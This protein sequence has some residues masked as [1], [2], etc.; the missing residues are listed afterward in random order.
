MSCVAES[1]FD[2]V[3]ELLD[4]I[5]EALKYTDGMNE[6]V[7][8]MRL[9][10]EWHFEAWLD[11]YKLKP[12]IHVTTCAAFKAE[13]IH[14]DPVNLNLNVKF[15]NLNFK[16]KLNLKL[17]IFLN[18][19]QEHR[20]AVYVKEA[21]HHTQWQSEPWV[22]IK[23]VPPGVPVEMP[24]Q[25]FQ[26]SEN[27]DIQKM[28]AALDHVVQLYGEETLSQAGCDAIKTV[29]LRQYESNYEEFEWPSPR[30]RAAI[31]DPM[32]YAFPKNTGM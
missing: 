20:V 19:M 15:Y 12:G 13:H 5:A 16:F 29:V 28:C 31:L 9:N 4:C 2:S 8:T 1:N 26:G 11:P 30:G 7:Q 17:Q 32:D 6:P 3:E 10:F 14:D 22:M 21:I 25:A 23:A 18:C 24:R 27:K